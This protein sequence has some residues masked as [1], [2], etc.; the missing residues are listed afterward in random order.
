MFTVVLALALLTGA[1]QGQSAVVYSGVQSIAIP[2]DFDG[3]YLNVLSG[4]TG[5]SEPGT[6][7]TAPWFNPFFGGVYTT[8]PALLRPASDGFGQMVNLAVGT[9]IDS[10]SNF[11]AAAGGSTTHVGGAVNQFQI[12]VPGYLGFEFEPTTGGQTQYGWMQITINN[13]GAGTIHGWAYESTAG[14][15][16][17]AGSV[18]EPGRALLL[19]LGLMGVVVRR[20]RR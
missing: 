15:G 10:T 8:N 19:M 4:A 7:D 18:P 17:L 6:W 16:I 9:M 11:A 1:P 3:V 12:S 5:F 2:L 14:T 13:T 20:R